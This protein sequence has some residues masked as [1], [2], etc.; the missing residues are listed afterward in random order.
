MTTAIEAAQILAGEVFDVL[1]GPD[2]TGRGA[3][4]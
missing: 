3:A 1:A 2:D 4:I